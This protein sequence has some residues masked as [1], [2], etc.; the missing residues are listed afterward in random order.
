ML[1][2]TKIS[3][4]RSLAENLHIEWAEADGVGTKGACHS[5]QFWKMNG[6]GNDF[7]IIDNIREQIPV[8]RF[9]TWPGFCASGI[10]RLAPTD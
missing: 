8:E 9:G 1:F 4:M 3:G 10:C 6:A 5:M 2:Q 7:I